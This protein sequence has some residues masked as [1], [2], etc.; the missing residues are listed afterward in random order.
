MKNKNQKRIRNRAWAWI[1]TA[2]L[3]I[4]SL[5]GCG[6]QT[7]EQTAQGEKTDG[8]VTITIWHDKEDAVTQVLE[9]EFAQLEPQIHVVLEK[10][11]DLTEALKMVGN[12]PKAAPDMYFFA[13]DKIGVYAEMDILSPITDIIP[14]EELDAY[15][16]NTIE[17]ATYKGTVYQLPI[18]YETL[19]FMYNRLYMKDEEVPATTE[20]LYAY[21]QEN[22]RGGH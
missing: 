22:T 6:S 5:T 16:D 8:E 11:S 7:V 2:G 19:L 20:E 3:T 10:K 9:E 17:A 13:H 14:A 4:G 18:Y 1:V 21:M 12:D 15:M